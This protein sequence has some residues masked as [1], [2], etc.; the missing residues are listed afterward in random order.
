MSIDNGVYR[1]YKGN[2]YEVLGVATHSETEEPYVVYRPL[3]GDYSLWIRPLS[4]FIE[5]VEVDGK[6]MP[7]FTFVESATEP[8]A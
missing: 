6:T 2:R 1:H 4:M 7:R 8:T 3:Y 5:T